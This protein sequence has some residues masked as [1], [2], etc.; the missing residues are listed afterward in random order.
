MRISSLL[1]AGLVL[2]S[3]VVAQAQLTSVDEAVELSKKT[4]KPIFA[5]A[6]N[7]TCPACV[8][9]Q[10]RLTT[11]RSL[12]AFSNQF[13][14][15]KVT[16]DGNADWGKWASKYPV[17]GR[18]IPIVYVIRADGE[19]LHAAAGAPQGEAL[20][21]LLFTSLERSGRTLT[22]AEVDVLSA[23]VAEAKAALT[24]G[25]PGPA[26]I[27]LAKIAKIGTLGDLKSYSE[28]AKEAD[29]L[30]QQVL[31]AAE[32]SLSAATEQVTKPDTAF[33][34]VLTLV[35]GERAYTVFP[36]I[37]TAMAKKVRELERNAELTEPMKQAQALDRARRL[38]TTGNPTLKAKAIEAYV[39]VITRFPGTAAEKLAVEELTKIDP[40]KAAAAK[41]APRPAESAA[42]TAGEFRKW[43]SGTFQVEAK[44]VQRKQGFVQLEKRDGGKISVPI[45][46]LSQADQDL[47]KSL[48]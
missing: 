4:G 10:E 39:S 28:L 35:E 31:E 46:K 12:A 42:P 45:E 1:A 16:T 23:S 14:P 29:A 9:L 33:E 32:K 19:R 44:L 37:K 18:A 8:A 13:I 43:T 48:P 26:A 41:D 5:M 15:L 24:A 22:N 20:H 25:T 40:E 11:D 7:Q 6:G 17:E 27:A 21:Q 34:G 38:P 3:G 36:K 30:T 47:L 2:W